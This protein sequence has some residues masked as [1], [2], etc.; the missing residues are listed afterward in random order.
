[1]TFRSDPNT[2]RGDPLFEDPDKGKGS[3]ERDS[4]ERGPC[5]HR[6][7]SVAP[8]LVIGG[9]FI[10]MG[11]ALLAGQLGY[12]GD[13]SAWQYWPLILILMGVVKVF[14]P[15]ASTPERLFGLLF[16]V[17]GGGV[18]A[19]YLGYIVLR[20]SLIWPGLILFLGMVIVV[21]TLFSSR[22]KHKERGAGKYTSTEHVIESIVVFGGREEKNT[23]KTFKGGDVVCVFGGC[24]VDLREAEIEGEEAVIHITAVMGGVEVQV[25][26]HWRPVLKGTPIMGGYE[27][28][29]RP[30]VGDL[31]G[32][33]PKLVIEGVA[34]MGGVE[35]KS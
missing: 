26:P 18:L 2:S 5:G 25:P 24:N 30:V 29:T 4:H 27:D 34:V 31:E 11:A 14:N 6:G 33:R 17:A 13:L 10:I 23:S 35:L 9:A 8:G 1:M 7:H 22:R 3:E 28:K 19:H 15:K 21:S 16:L 20:W 12:L 32:P